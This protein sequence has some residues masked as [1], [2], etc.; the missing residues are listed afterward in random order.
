MNTFSQNAETN[1]KPAAVIAGGAN[2]I[3]E[4][5]AK[6]LS[7]L[8]YPVAI[9]DRDARGCER[10]ERWVRERRRAFMS[11]VHDVTDLDQHRRVVERI[12]KTLGPVGVFVNAASMGV[13][14]S[15]R[16]T[17]PEDLDAVL[18][19]NLRGPF[20]L[21][22]AILRVMLKDGSVVFITS[23]HQDEPVGDPTYSMSKAALKVLV[24]ELALELGPKRRI[25]VNGIA[26]GAIRHRKTVEARFSRVPLGQRRGTPEEV[27][28]V[29]A[30]LV[31]PDASY[32]T[33]ELV[34]VD[35]GLSLVNW[36][37]TEGMQP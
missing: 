18:N 26:P 27:A 16:R 4:A 10:M 5:I 19:T 14:H 21:T 36:I 24:K 13:S 1:Q 31:S 9:V 32:I 29:V 8:G 2:G 7:F 20:F 11:I 37:S 35:A 23:V 33:G 34:T 6:R 25:R 17:T 12:R 15:F 22:Q 30:F 28:R 3:G